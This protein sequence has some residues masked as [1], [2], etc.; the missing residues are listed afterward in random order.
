[1]TAL[2]PPHPEDEVRLDCFT[3]KTATIMRQWV[4]DE[5]FTLLAAWLREGMVTGRMR[6][7]IKQLLRKTLGDDMIGLYSDILKPDALLYPMSLEKKLR[8]SFRPL[9]PF[10]L[11]SLR[12]PLR[13]Q[14]CLLRLIHLFFRGALSRKP[15]GLTPM[16]CSTIPNW[17]GRIQNP[18]SRIKETCWRC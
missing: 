13:Y 9:L 8:Q 3:A 1:M 6:T 12:P 15:F 18:L 14:M 4:K 10:L 7:H 2:R 11:L 16:H 17:R 5:P